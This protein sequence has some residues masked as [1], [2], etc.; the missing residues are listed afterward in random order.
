MTY[1]QKSYTKPWLLLSS[2]IVSVSNGRWPWEND[3]K[4]IWPVPKQTVSHGGP[5]NLQQKETCQPISVCFF[6]WV[7]VLNIFYLHPYLGK[8][9]IL[10][11]I[12]QM[13]WNHQPEDFWQPT[14]KKSGR[15]HENHPF[16]VSARLAGSGGTCPA[17]A[18][19]GG[20]NSGKKPQRYFWRPPKWKVG[21]LVYPP[22]N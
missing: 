12:F 1:S 8:I 2:R 11:N 17:K 7:V 6:F 14:K 22:W 4:L 13:G 3:E 10:T 20:G 5:L 16:S 15:P 18:G 9:P 19:S 21:K